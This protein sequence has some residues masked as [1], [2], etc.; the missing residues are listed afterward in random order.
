MNSPEASGVL[1]VCTTQS[2]KIRL[3]LSHSLTGDTK[4][5]SLSNPKPKHQAKLFFDTF[6]PGGMC[7]RA[8][9]VIAPRLQHETAWGR[10]RQ[11]HRHLRACQE[12]VLCTRRKGQLRGGQR[13]VWCA[14][15]WL[16]HASRSVAS[17]SIHSL[18][19]PFVAQQMDGA[20]CQLSWGFLT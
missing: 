9:L 20:M 2:A 1:V 7:E 14:S 5:S 15:W 12:R 19:D 13:G 6:G 17:S 10:A 4:M 3:L 11:Q 16:V 8:M 18:R